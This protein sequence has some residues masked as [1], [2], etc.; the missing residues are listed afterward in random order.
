ME[1]TYLLHLN[2]IITIE[3]EHASRIVCGIHLVIVPRKKVINH[4]I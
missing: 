2:E 1:W 4:T 3:N